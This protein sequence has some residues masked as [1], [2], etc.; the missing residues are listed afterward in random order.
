L[1]ETGGSFV[2]TTWEDA[3]AAY[4]LFELS[5][6]LYIPEGVSLDEITVSLQNVRT[7]FAVYVDGGQNFVLN[8]AQMFVPGDRAWFEQSDG[9]TINGAAANY[10]NEIGWDQ[11]SW[12]RNDM[13]HGIAARE[14]FYTLETLI[15]IAES[16]APVE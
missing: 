16:V 9:L 4:M 15:R 12:F 5:R 7:V 2:F 8:Y 13:I 14:G 3:Q 6:P 10:R 11:I 1:T